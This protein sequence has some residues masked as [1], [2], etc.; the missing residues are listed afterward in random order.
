MHELCKMGAG[1]KELLVLRARACVC[2][3]ANIILSTATDRIHCVSMLDIPLCIIQTKKIICSEEGTC[4]CMHIMSAGAHFVL[5]LLPVCVC[6]YV[7]VCSQ[8]VCVDHCA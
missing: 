3:C 5:V 7:C 4:I 1:G 8:R 2:M 6:V